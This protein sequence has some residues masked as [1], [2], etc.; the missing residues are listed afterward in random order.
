MRR[1]S[2]CSGCAERREGAPRTEEGTHRGCPYGGIWQ[3]GAFWGGGLGHPQGVPLRGIGQV[4]SAWALPR[5][6]CLGWLTFGTSHDVGGGAGRRGTTTS[7]CPHTRCG[8]R[9]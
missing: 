7:H 5:L 3:G 9:F 4:G 6:A 2:N 1:I 8:A